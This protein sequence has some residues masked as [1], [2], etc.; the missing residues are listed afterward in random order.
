MA[1]QFP[2]ILEHRDAQVALIERRN[3]TK[4]WDM[5]PTHPMEWPQLH[6]SREYMLT[7]GFT[8]EQL[9]AADAILFAGVSE[10]GQAT[11]TQLHPEMTAYPF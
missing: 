3:A 11:V 1:Q 7:N 8:Q 4:M 6:Y 10:D 9:D 5:M 2:E